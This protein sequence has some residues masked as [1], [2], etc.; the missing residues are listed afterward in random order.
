MANKKLARINFEIEKKKR[1]EFLEKLR[2]EG[3]N[4][5]RWFTAK[6]NEYLEVKK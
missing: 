6:I 4:V 2:E 3:Y 1:K 5:R